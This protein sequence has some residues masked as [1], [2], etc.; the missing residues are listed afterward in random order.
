M[1]KNSKGWP[2]HSKEILHY[3][4]K[5]TTSDCFEKPYDWIEKENGF[6]ELESAYEVE[7]AAYNTFSEK[8][9]IQIPAACIHKTT[10]ETIR[11]LKEK[12]LKTFHMRFT[13]NAS[14]D[15]YKIP[16]CPLHAKQQRLSQPAAFNSPIMST[17]NKENMNTA[18]H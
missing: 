7:K 3:K 6:S 16:G 5:W 4:N 2:T 15:K 1:C 11:C 18:Q 17:S 12:R 8:K 10:Q 13:Q 14:L 9:T